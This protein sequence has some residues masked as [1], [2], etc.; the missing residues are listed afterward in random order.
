MHGIM[1]FL[2]WTNKSSPFWNNMA[3]TDDAFGNY[4]LKPGVT[5]SAQGWS[6]E[7]S[8][9]WNATSG[10]YE[11]TSITGIQAVIADW[12]NVSE[13]DFITVKLVHS[14]SGKVIF[15]SEVEVR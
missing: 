4:T 1:K 10:S 12:G 8:G 9:T 5:M 13:G 11:G 3:V 15:D 6:N 2:F 14:P 7:D